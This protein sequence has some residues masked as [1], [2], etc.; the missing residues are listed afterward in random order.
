MAHAFARPVVSTV[1][2]RGIAS[3]LHVEIS[4]SLANP[5]AIT[6][7]IHESEESTVTW[8]ISTEMIQDALAKHPTW[9]RT[10]SRETLATSGDVIVTKLFNGFGFTRKQG[11]RIDLQGKFDGPREATSMYFSR[12]MIRNFMCDVRNALDDFPVAEY[13]Y[14]RAGIANLEETLR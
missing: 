4:Y 10:A 12:G 3:T 14:I 1:Y 5:F 7:N 8:H 9:R 13:E 6:L 2:F 11:I